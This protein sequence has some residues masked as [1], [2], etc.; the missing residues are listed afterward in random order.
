MG[1]VELFCF[2]LFR[3]I[4]NPK[5]LV[6]MTCLFLRLVLY[7]ILL[8]RCGDFHALGNATLLHGICGGALHLY[9]THIQHVFILPSPDR[10]H[11]V[12]RPL[13]QRRQKTHR[14]Y[15]GL[16]KV[17]STGRKKK[18]IWEEFESRRVDVRT[19]GE[20]CALRGMKNPW[21]CIS[22]YWIHERFLAIW[23]ARPAR[24]C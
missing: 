21:W 6:H 24:L 12:I 23:Q 10:C 14:L 15:L 20:S 18:H 8:W 17:K 9:E 19:R 22:L 13:L 2:V 1:F 11:G 3:W 16:Q 7:I 4:W 5:Q